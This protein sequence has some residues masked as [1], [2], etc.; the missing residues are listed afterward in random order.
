MLTDHLRDEI[1]AVKELNE[2]LTQEYQTLSRGDLS[3]LERLADR[4]QLCADRLEALLERR[5]ELQ[6]PE[7]G[8]PED[9]P[10]RRAE[11]Q[12]L[13]EELRTLGLQARRQNAVNG[14]VVAA[15]KVRTEQALGLLTG[16]GARPDTY[17]RDA[18]L[19]GS[20]QRRRVGVA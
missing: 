1:A 8:G 20:G 12:A 14:R 6:V 2:V 15:S 17:D 10:G 11:R 4:K 9:T 13:Q 7:R 18:R 16:A 3:G 19:A 5:R